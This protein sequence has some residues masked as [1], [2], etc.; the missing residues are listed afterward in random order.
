M[1]HAFM[2]AISQDLIRNIRSFGEKK[3]SSSSNPKGCR[4]VG[5]VISSF[6]EFSTIQGWQDDSNYINM[7]KR[8]L[9]HDKRQ[10]YVMCFFSL[11]SSQ[12]CSYPFILVSCPLLFMFTCLLVLLLG[13]HVT[14]L[15][16]CRWKRSKVLITFVIVFLSSRDIFPSKQC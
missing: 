5:H 7:H 12:L 15:S 8:K 2:P 11:A 13:V 16:I 6:W 14:L 3:T 4:T 9:P 10:I 1:C